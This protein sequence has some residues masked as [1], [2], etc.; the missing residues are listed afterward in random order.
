[1]GGRRAGGARRRAAAAA[2]AALALDGAWW[3]YD[4]YF[5][6]TLRVTFLAVGQGDGAVVRFPGSRVMLIDAGGSFS[7]EF[8]PGERLVAAY[9]WSQKIMHVEYLV[10]SHP[11]MDHFG[12]FNFIARNFSPAEFWAIGAPSP[13]RKYEALLEVLAA[14]G[15]RLRLMDSR[16]AAREIG[17]VTVVC[18]NPDP[19]LSASRNDS[20]MMLMLSFGQNRILFTGDIEARGEEAVIARGGDLHAT[21]IKVPHHGSRTSSTPEFVAA[22]RPTLAVMSLGYRNRYGFPEPG[23]VARYREAGAIVLRTDQ[24]GAVTIEASPQ[25][26]RWSAR[27][28]GAGT[29]GRS[30][31][32]STVVS[33]ASKPG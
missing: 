15:V 22:V 1:M 23:V 3:T 19:T 24:C 13:D 8:D 12:G 17:G 27:G 11:E 31:R 5:E 28:C 16:A 20:S 26:A 4:R 32:P 21:V 7:D 29:V 9:L 14:T 18:L 2:I 10:L 6:P 33:S 25:Q 30:A